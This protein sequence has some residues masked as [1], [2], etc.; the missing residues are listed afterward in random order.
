MRSNPL[1][2]YH[3]R[4]NNYEFPRQP[5]KLPAAHWA[6]WQQALTRLLIHPYSHS[7]QDLATPLGQWIQQDSTQWPW[8]YREASG[9]I[10][11]DTTTAGEST[12][13][14]AMPELAGPSTDSPLQRPTSSM[15]PDADV[16]IIGAPGN[17]V[18][19]NSYC[20]NGTQPH[21]E[22]PAPLTLSQAVEQV[23]DSSRWANSLL[24]STSAPQ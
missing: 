15:E 5:D 1:E 6:L 10:Y 14:E 24:H 21:Q 2:E 13:P 3:R 11:K 8:F 16:T 4:A 23:D 7:G 9:L 22:A 18:K 20:R 12:P 19:L 17:T